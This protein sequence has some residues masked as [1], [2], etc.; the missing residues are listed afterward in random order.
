MVSWGIAVGSLIWRCGGIL[1]YQNVRRN[2]LGIAQLT[3][4]VNR[5][6]TLFVQDLADTP[7]W[8]YKIDQL[9]AGKT[10]P[11]GFVFY[12]RYRIQG[13]DRVRMPP[14]LD[15]SEF[16]SESGRRRAVRDRL[17]L[18][19]TEPVFRRIRQAGV[20]APDRG[21]P[22]PWVHDKQGFAL[23]RIIHESRASLDPALKCQAKFEESPRR[24]KCQL[25]L[26]CIANE[27]DVNNPGSGALDHYIGLN[28]TD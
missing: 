3:D 28:R 12:R 13:V 24:T 10:A 19:S 16:A 9:V 20:T 14:G 2:P 17:L 4:H 5:Q 23:T 22:A 18:V 15:R 25:T 7:A 21:C 8:S 26:R 1:G 27:H 11:F 6:W